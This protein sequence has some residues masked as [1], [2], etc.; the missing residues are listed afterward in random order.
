MKQSIKYVCKCSETG[1]YVEIEFN[2]KLEK[3]DHPNNPDSK[4]KIMYLHSYDLAHTDCPEC[5]RK[6]GICQ[7]ERGI[8]NTTEN[9]IIIQGYDLIINPNGINRSMIA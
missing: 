6:I 9:D 1:D 2:D 5:G 7:L 8:E 4:L 3:Y